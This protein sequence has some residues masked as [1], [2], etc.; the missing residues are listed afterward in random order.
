MF[1]LDAYLERIGCSGRPALAE[2]HRAHVTAIPFENLDPLS[3]RPVSLELAD[4]QRKLV[5][6]H[7]GG[8]C[9]E[10]N[11]LF[12]AALEALGADVELMLGRVGPRDLATRGRT[13]LVL[14]VRAEGTIWHADVGYGSGTLLEPVPFGEGGPYA[15]SGW[16]FRVVAHDRQLVLQERGRD[17]AWVDEYSFAPEPVPF[18]DVETSNWFT[19]THPRSRFVRGLVVSASA[20]DG[21]RTVI[22]DWSGALRL[23]EQTPAGET[24]TDLSHDAVP[25][26]LATRFGLPGWEFDDH[27]RPRSRRSGG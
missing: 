15:Q 19:S 2:L 9:F 26:L 10:H 8:Y 20:V 24:V 4:V 25:E 13:H 17:G 12:K 23:M 16:E 3:G 18:V 27:G 6:E 14:R 22:S 1:D 7:R 21:S 5:T 11:T